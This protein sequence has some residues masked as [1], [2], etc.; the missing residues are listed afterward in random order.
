M[1]AHYCEYHKKKVKNVTPAIADITFL[2]C[3]SIFMLYNG[4]STYTRKFG[5]LLSECSKATWRL[6]E[7]RGGALRKFKLLKK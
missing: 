5:A 1:N 4:A 7:T 3:S 2:K 6:A